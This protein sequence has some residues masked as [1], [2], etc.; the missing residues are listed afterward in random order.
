MMEECE[1]SV[2]MMVVGVMEV[3]GRRPSQRQRGSGWG[4]EHWKVGLGRGATFEV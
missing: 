2:G 4:K 3:G 1:V